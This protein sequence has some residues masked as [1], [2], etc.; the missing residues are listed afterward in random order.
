MIASAWVHPWALVPD[1]D[2]ARRWLADE[3]SRSE[4]QESWV[5]RFGRWVND[6]LDTLS[7]ASGSLGHLNPLLAAVL[8]LVLVALL[9]FA[10]SRLR[11]NAALPGGGSAV[12]AEVRQGAG[13]HRAAARAALEQGHWEAVVES[14]RALAAGLVERGLVPEQTDLTVHE[15]TDNASGLYPSLAGRLRRT[16]VAFDETRYGDRA[17]NEERAREAVAL[18]EQVSRQAPETS[19]GRAPVSAVPR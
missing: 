8:A 13:E 19:G 10:L 17:A 3:L 14:V 1:P 4:Y 15:L 9:T 5:E 18:E 11:R 6:L 16:G 2:Q 12:F 7:R